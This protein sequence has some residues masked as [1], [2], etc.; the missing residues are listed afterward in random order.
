MVVLEFMVGM[1]QKPGRWALLIIFETEI[2][3][4]KKILCVVLCGMLAYTSFSQPICG[5]DD[6]HKKMMANPGYA[7]KMRWGIPQPETVRD[8]SI[9]G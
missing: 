9:E 4:M 7:E 2:T 5:F 1:H 3:P 8:Y 6:G